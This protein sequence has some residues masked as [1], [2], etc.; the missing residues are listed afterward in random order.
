MIPQKGQHIRCLLR[1]NLIIDGIVESW[2]DAKSV[3]RSLDDASVS[4]IQHSA[5]DIVVIKI[6][7]REPEKVKGDLSAQFTEQLAKPSD[8]EFRLKNMAELKTLLNE[9]EKKIIAEKLKDHHVGDVKKVA[10]GQ[11]GFFKKPRPE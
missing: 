1:N 9:Q 8:D 6:I 11:P 2:S 7:L 10:Y 3:L 4:I 5:Q